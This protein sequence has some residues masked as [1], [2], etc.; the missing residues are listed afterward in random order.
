MPLTT[1]SPVAL[2]VTGTES[3]WPAVTGVVLTEVT[4]TARVSGTLLIAVLT[5]VARGGV[6]VSTT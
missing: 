3:F 1:R 5:T 4:A 2:T 6:P